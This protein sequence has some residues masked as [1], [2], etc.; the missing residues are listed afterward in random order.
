MTDGS[1]YGL[2]HSISNTKGLVYSTLTK[3]LLIK[4]AG[5]I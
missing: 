2:S 5:G 3:N 1:I 4:E